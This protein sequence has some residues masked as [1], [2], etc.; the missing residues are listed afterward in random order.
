MILL[1]INLV[2]NL[3]LGDIARWEGVIGKSRHGMMTRLDPAIVPRRGE[4]PGLASNPD[5]I[6]YL[7]C[8]R[9]L[10]ILPLQAP[11]SYLI[12]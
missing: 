4:A 2:Q 5:V 6:T 3:T 11:V 7:L 8:D 1:K 12:R 9:G 10:I